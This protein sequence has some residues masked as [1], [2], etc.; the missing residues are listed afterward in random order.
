MQISYSNIFKIAWRFTIKNKILW[1]FGFF[2]SFLS[3][4][5][6]Y[7]II[8]NNI[9]QVRN[10]E[11]FQQ[12]IANL[13]T[14][15]F[16]FLGQQ[17][18][19]LNI[20]AQDIYRSLIFMLC[21]FLCLFMLW[22]IFASQIFI[23]KAA[24]SLYHTKRFKS[25]NIF[26]HG[27]DKIWQVFSINILS[28]LVLYAC[29]IA[30]NLPLLFLFFQK[31][32]LTISALI[33][34]LL[35]YIVLAIII[36]FITA[37]ATNFI[38]IKNLS[39]LEA[40]KEA[41]LL[42]SANIALSLETAFILFCLKFLSL[43]IILCT[44]LLLLVPLTILLLITYVTNSLLG[45]ILI[46]TLIIL[47]LILIWALGSSLYTVFY[48][49]TWTI[50][51]I[52]LT[53]VS[54]ISKSL[55]FAQKVLLLS[56]NIANKLGFKFDKKEMGR[57]AKIIAKKTKAEAEIIGSELAKK[58]IEYKPIVKKQSKILYKKAVKEYQK[59]KPKI[60]K[61]IFNFINFKA[62]KTKAKKLK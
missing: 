40:I 36:S 35:I 21:I 7:E 37:Y 45:F 5:S 54:F 9:Y 43:I 22:L 11:D 58:Y 16:N 50:T 6:V 8:L 61:S 60:K 23:I 51:F 52:K 1:I 56:K 59:A 62:K 12:K 15:Q 46:A 26:S 28:K 27:N 47:A 18:F 48:L 38:I 42:F 2:A 14:D 53:E 32:Y 41:W 17:F 44:F 29:F 34:Y 33:V 49:N 24:A 4:E 39:I 19:L 25:L 31:E 57:Q 30:L 55:Y 20:S 10:L 13:T 3:L